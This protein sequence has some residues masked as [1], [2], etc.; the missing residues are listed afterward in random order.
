MCG[1]LLPPEKPPGIPALERAQ[2]GIRAHLARPGRPI[3]GL[4]PGGSRLGSLP[5][6]GGW[7]GLLRGEDALLFAL[8]GYAEAMGAKGALVPRVL[9]R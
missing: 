6:D 8:P 1:Q 9:R 7:L 3:T 5:V 4:C 2:A